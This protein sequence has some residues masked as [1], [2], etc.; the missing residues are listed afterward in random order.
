[1]NFV[2]TAEM[3]F[4]A[5]DVIGLSR[6]VECTNWFQELDLAC[7]L[8]RKLVSSAYRSSR[9]ADKE[10]RTRSIERVI[11]ISFSAQ[12]NQFKNKIS[13]SV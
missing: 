12:L 6:S 10:C 7:S 11:V 1:M 5:A 8:L 9:L 2:E 3:L 4:H 13:V